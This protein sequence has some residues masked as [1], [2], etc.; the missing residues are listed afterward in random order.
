MLEILHDIGLDKNKFGKFG[1]LS[2]HKN[3]KQE[4]K[5][6]EKQTNKNIT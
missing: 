4:Q 3:S 1:K 5:N 2:S 6:I